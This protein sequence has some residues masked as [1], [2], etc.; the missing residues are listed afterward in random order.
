MPILI[1]EDE[2][3]IASNLA[4]GVRELGN[5]V[6]GPFGSTEEA[7]ELADFATGAIL[8]VRIGQSN[9]FPVAEC[10]LN[11]QI[12]FIF[13]TGIPTSI[14]G[15]M[16]S[17]PRFGKLTSIGTMLQ[18][19]AAESARRKATRPEDDIVEFLPLMRLRARELLGDACAADRLVE[20]ALATAIE[21]RRP[22]LD[23]AELE[24]WLQTLLEDEFRRRGRQLLS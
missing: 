7:I 13:Y 14:P 18:A 11:Q 22:R 3:L 21:T 19:L 2:Y 4:A 15:R 5:E 23:S 24:D 12:P 20:A 17:I 1:L 16:A 9:S 8:D 10:L 6:I